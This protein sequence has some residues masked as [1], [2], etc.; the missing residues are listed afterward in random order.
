MQPHWDFWGVVRGSYLYSLFLRKRWLGSHDDDLIGFT[1]VMLVVQPLLRKR[2]Y[3]LCWNGISRGIR[4]CYCGYLCG[5][6]ANV[7]SKTVSIGLPNCLCWR[8][9][10]NQRS[11]N[12]NDMVWTDFISS[13]VRRYLFY[14]QWFRWQLI[15]EA[16]VVSNVEYSLT[17]TQWF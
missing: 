3:V 2:I 10:V 5:K 4:C 1:G 14:R 17:S 11:L 15:N 13:G 9:C 12:G 16:N 6:M 8:C 7:E